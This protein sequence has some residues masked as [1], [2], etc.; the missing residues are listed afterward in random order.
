MEVREQPTLDVE[1]ACLGELGMMGVQESEKLLLQ[2]EQA[3]CPVVH[4]FGP[5]IYIR[6][7]FIPAGT[8]A[9][10]HRQ[11]HEHVNVML[12]G[13]V[14]MVNDDGSTQ[15]LTAPLMFIGKPGRKVGY[16]VEDMVW[17]NIYATNERDITKLEAFFLDKSPAFE[18]HTTHHALTYDTRTDQED[19]ELMLRDTGF[20]AETVHEQSINMDDQIPMP[21][22]S[23]RV[24]TGPSSIHG[25]GVFVTS[26]VLPGE[27]LGP[28]RIGGK[29]T[30]LGR[31]TNHSAKPNARMELLPNGDVQLVTTQALNGCRG[32]LD[33]DE[34]TIDYR[35]AISLAFEGDQP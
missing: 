20:D 12:K 11:K 5:G 14:I 21:A 7:L 24:K 9:I 3:A 13:R 26:N 27:I 30:P 1:L 25:T 29:R 8:Y 31:Y 35:Q 32:G 19:F 17:Q 4:H 18:E 16:V 6:E 10:G 22:G 23:W 34:V 28:A 15:E 2:H 33:G